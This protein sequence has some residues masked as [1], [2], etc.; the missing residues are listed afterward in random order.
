MMEGIISYIPTRF[1]TDQEIENCLPLQLTS[2]EEWSPHSVDFMTNE[3]A[4]GDESAFIAPD[5]QV[6]AIQSKYI[7]NNT[8]CMS[9]ILLSN[10][11]VTHA[12]ISAAS[13]GTRVSSTTKET[14]SRIFHIGLE[15]AKRTLDATTQMAV[16]NVI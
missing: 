15:T 8:S 1:P 10:V 11:N 12:N 3:L 6:Y 4:A 7:A 16:K 2:T 5:R 14:L 9:N 13:S